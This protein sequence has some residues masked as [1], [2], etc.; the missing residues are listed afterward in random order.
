MR[1]QHRPGLDW[2]KRRV[3]SLF[4]EACERIDHSFPPDV[5]EWLKFEPRK[6]AAEWGLIFPDSYGFHNH[7]SFKSA[8]V[9]LHNDSFDGRGISLRRKIEQW[10][11]DEEDTPLQLLPPPLPPNPAE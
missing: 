8:Y 11:K 3:R 4:H 2:C 6:E 5:H 9:K 7:A 10:L 1:A